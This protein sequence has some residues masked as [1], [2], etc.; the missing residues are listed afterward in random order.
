VHE[1]VDVDPKKRSTLQDAG[2][3]LGDPTNTRSNRSDFEEPPLEL[4]ATE[5]MPP[6][7]IF[8]V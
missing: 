4:T 6:R 2:D 5:L 8:L 1:D 3:L 7:N